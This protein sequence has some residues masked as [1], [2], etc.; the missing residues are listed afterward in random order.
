[1]SIYVNIKNIRNPLSC[2]FSDLCLAFGNSILSLVDVE[3]ISE[4]LTAGRRSKTS[5]T[6]ALSQWATREIRKMK[7]NW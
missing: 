7:N 1:M 3:P 2:L 5:K 6:K 4:L